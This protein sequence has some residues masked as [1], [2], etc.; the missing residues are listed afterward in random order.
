MHT[1]LIGGPTIRSLWLGLIMAT[2]A[3]IVLATSI[4]TLYQTAFEEERN[5]LIETTQSQ[6]RLIEA[7]ARFAIAHGAKHPMA[8]AL[9]QIREAH[10]RF[11]GLGKTGEFTLARLQGKQ[12]VFLLNHRHHD[13][14]D[15]YP[16]TL[17]GVQAA[18]MRQALQ[19]ESGSLVGP[20]YRGETVLAAYEPVAELNLG[21]VAKIDL[22]EIRAPFIH[23]AWVSSAIA[24]VLILLGAGAFRRITKR[25]GRRVEQSEKLFRET[26]AHAAIGLA[27]VAID[28]KWLRVNDALCNIVG[29]SREEL[30]RLTFHDI[31]HPD[32]LD[33]DL[34]HITQ[35]LAGDIDTYAIEKRY[36]RK[37][38]SIVDVQLTVSLVRDSN[39]NPDYF[40]SAVA[41]IS[42][43]KQAMATIKTISGI[44]PLCAWCGNAIRNEDGDWV[45][46]YKYIEKHSDAQISHGM[47]PACRE[48]LAKSGGK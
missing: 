26:F 8:A 32:D 21:V 44:V 24:L 48:S 37:D 9:A 2:I 23:A 20:D 5:R 19:G 40:V 16:V 12:I 3:T 22:K 1:W 18:P 47:C 36:I 6:A 43:L 28:G 25:I 34:Q 29:Y 33:A 38:G 14:S 42:R 17:D 7:I 11:A 10:E 39:A 30:M 15:L 46:V 31:T 41:D 13:L 27:H 35:T 45:K 4:I